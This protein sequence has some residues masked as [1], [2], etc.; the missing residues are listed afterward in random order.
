MTVTPAGASTA[1]LR[2]KVEAD[3][4]LGSSVG[5]FMTG[6]ILPFAGDVAPEGRFAFRFQVE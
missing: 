5:A 4:D 3:R 6:D 2:G 1:L